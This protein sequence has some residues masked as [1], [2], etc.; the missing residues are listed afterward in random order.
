MKAALWA[1]GM[2]LAGSTVGRVG[3]V[4]VVVGVS[5]LSGSMLLA[6]H[7]DDAQLLAKLGPVASGDWTGFLLGAAQI[8][9]AGGM[10]GFAVVLAWMFGREFG[11]GTITGLFALP[12]RRSTISLAKLL[13][14][15]AWAVAMSAALGLSLLFVGLI[16]GL[17]PLTTADAESL[18][19]QFALGVMSAAI[20][21][22]VAW[23]AT[24][25]RSVLG[26][27]SVAIALVVVAQVS[28]LAG[29]G[30]WMPLAAPALWAVSG[31]TAVSPLQLV[32][33]VPF[34]AAAVIA[35]AITWARL[36]LDR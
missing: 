17:G 7:S 8:T 6:A 33:V 35:T 26:G 1:E 32:L 19:R 3:S 2:K 25:S 14:Y 16:A 11:D 36:Q 24:L 20:A 21:I 31:G 15:A 13:V 28:V 34:A 22:P 5:V 9:G 4:A 10:G 30:G 18:V 29:I 27:V 23:A 12:V